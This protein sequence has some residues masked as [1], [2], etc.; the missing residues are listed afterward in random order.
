MGPS[1]Q[2]VVVDF[3]SSQ[4]SGGDVDGPVTAARLAEVHAVPTRES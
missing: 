2:E 1:V 4:S 3:A